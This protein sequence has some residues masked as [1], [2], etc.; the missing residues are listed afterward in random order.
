[1]WLNAKKSGIAA[2]IE[3]RYNGQFPSLWACVRFLATGIILFIKISQYKK[4]S[5]FSL[6]F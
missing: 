1:V 5:L 6:P 4:S 2:L 3:E